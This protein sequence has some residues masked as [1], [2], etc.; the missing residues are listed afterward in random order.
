[1]GEST[2][3]E[4]SISDDKS[5][6][7]VPPTPSKFS[8][9]L[10]KSSAV[11]RKSGFESAPET[12][13][14]RKSF[15]GKKGSRL[16]NSQETGNGLEP[17]VI[18]EPA[19]R[20]STVVT[21]S[22]SIPSIPSKLSGWLSHLHPSP[23]SPSPSDFTAL[24]SSPSHPTSL[25]TSPKSR[26][27]VGLIT[28]ARHSKSHLDRAMRY[29]M[30]SDV[31][32]GPPGKEPL[33][34]LGREYPSNLITE[35]SGGGWP[36]SFW[37]DFASIPWITY[38]SS[39]PAPIKDVPLSTLPAPYAIIQQ[40]SPLP[41]TQQQPASPITPPPSSS[42]PS[43]RF[44]VWQAVS[45]G[46]SE[47]SWTSDSGWGCMLRTGQSMLAQ[48]LLQL[49]L[50]HTSQTSSNSPQGQSISS[51]PL[52]SSSSQTSVPLQWSRCCLIAHII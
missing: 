27:A 18:I 11:N 30:D 28:A 44:N 42:S 26:A 36:E 12:S 13:N 48:A 39:Y 21:E 52:P 9:F 50:G 6:S 47:R 43:K 31:I 14:Q 38:R 24:L 32:T 3:K 37:N 10:P 15:L 35:E 5:M 7:Q 40:P 8:K 49:H 46:F 25:L 45:G 34:L 29:I 20:P 16:F 4:D 33:W 2:R 19:P 17:P 51:A 1:M 22:I 23:S 41:Q